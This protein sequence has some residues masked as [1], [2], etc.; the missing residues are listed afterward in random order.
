VKRK[1]DDDI[2]STFDC[3][4][5]GGK[6]ELSAGERVP[7]CTFCDTTLFIDR[8]G[9]VGH[10]L[11]PRLLDRE[12]AVEALN[13]WMSGN[14]TVKNLDRKSALAGIEPVTFPM[15]LFRCR[16][17]GAETVIIEPAAPTPIPQLV[18]L[19]LPPGKLEPFEA[20]DSA[21]RAVPATV[22]LE[23]ARSWIADRGLDD[24]FESALVE[25]PLWEA[26]YTYEGREYQALVDGATGS[27][28]ASVF[29]E[30]A[31]SPYVL[32]AL[33]GI[34]LFGIEGLVI[35][36]LFVKLVAYALTA[37]PLALLAYWVTRRV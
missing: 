17:E 5:C 9:V 27:V 26:R 16:R 6:N 12:R 1:V 21:V 35:S 13:R 14:E 18:D 20:A 32:V 11:V 36:N 19:E 15:W 4:R 34:V 31:E 10:F 29:P 2:L 33:A 37:I 23:T 7:V 8:S 3:P 22:P 30:K 28:I 24:V 25:V